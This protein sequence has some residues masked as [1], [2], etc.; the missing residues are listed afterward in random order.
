MSVPEG[1]RIKISVPSTTLQ[2]ICSYVAIAEIKNP[3][4]S[5]RELILHTLYTFEEEKAS[6]SQEVSCILR[7][8][9]GI[10]APNHQIQE[11]LDHLMSTEQVL[12]PLGTNY[13]LSADT[14]TKVKVR[15]DQA[16][17]LQDRVKINWQE[18]IE[19]RFPSIDPDLAWLTLQDYLA[20][21]FLRHGIQVAVFLDTS[22]E[23]P[24]EYATSLSTLL[25]EAV[26]SNFDLT[27][28]ESA[29]NAISD[30]LANVGNNQERAQYIAEC[31]DGAA[32]YFSLSVS[33]EV[34][35]K[36]RE[37]LSRLSLF[38][39]TNFLFGI[40]DLHVHPLVEVS[41]HLL[42][43]IE[44][45]CLPISLHC[46]E[47]TLHELQSSILHYSYILRKHSWRQAMSR[48]ATISPFL[49]G[50]ERKYHQINAEI[51][52]D[53]ETFLRPYQHVDELLKQHKINICT[54]EDDR[55]MER[56][57]MEAEYKEY[58]SKLQ[59]EK[60]DKLIIHDVKV[61]DYVHSLQDI[62][63]STLEAGALFVSC[64]Y[65]LYR[66]DSE[67]S[68]RAGR[69]ASVVI[70][71]IL[72]QILRPFIPTNTDF[73]KCFAETFAIPEIRTIGSDASVACSKMLGLLAVYKDL[74]EE[75]A[76]KLLS[77]DLLMNRLNAAENDKQFQMEVESAIAAEN[78]ALIEERT[79]LTKQV[80]A[81]R[82]DKE[83]TEKELEKQKQEAD[84]L[85]T[86]KEAAIAKAQEM[87]E[88]LS[89]AEETATEEASRREK[90]EERALRTA[91]VASII[92]AFSVSLLFEILINT[93]LRWDW[94]LNHPQSYGLQG[95]LCLMMSF[96]IVGLWVKSW[97]KVLL[98]TGVF[99]LL[100][101]G[102]QMLGGPTNN[103]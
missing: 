100:F 48:A 37:K 50:I 23:L 42:K 52:I 40:L 56:A 101:V 82:S 72:W 58:L 41:N 91:K 32:N 26:E 86:S 19:N 14:R 7:T 4:E 103:P 68:R 47:A 11:S 83:R 39:D 36:F 3:S 38:C 15:T 66:F 63:S 98:A 18:E 95:C 20:Q 57:T 71:N 76:V 2:Q 90:A 85:K 59:R 55:L 9:F 46:H 94:L 43:V 89:T 79:V 96:S 25:N 99:G 102:L 29:K 10:D 24:T 84:E 35:A 51:G 6:N 31:A 69:Q 54:S 61:L 30:F 65:M 64:D 17:N 28:Q 73:N 80:E 77:N 34:T 5:L 21:A 97:R 88:R 45:Y 74:P 16:S 62:T 78:Q 22:V 44:D 75:T 81:I 27:N 53:V 60:F 33:P 67:T 49:S 92:V 8:I 87:S 13:V 1:S 12:R 70:P 93:V